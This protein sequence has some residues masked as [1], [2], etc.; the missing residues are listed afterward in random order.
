MKLKSL[1]VAAAISL[2]LGTASA[3]GGSFVLTGGVGTFTG[4]VA[5]TGSFSD[6]WTF[7]LPTDITS[8]TAVVFSFQRA[9]LD[10]DF[11]SVVLTGGP[12][13][14]NFAA[15][16]LE[17]DPIETWELTLPSMF[18]GNYS[19]TLNGM[20]TGTQSVSYFGDVQV[21]PVPEPETYALALAA[22]GLFAVGSRLN[23]KS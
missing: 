14:V 22:L 10:I 18:A 15:T 21:T 13:A 1:A 9:T 5:A 20:K 4:A 11:S 8:G 19:L 17:G 6:V 7:S 16:K 3:A 12:N 23:R 2:S